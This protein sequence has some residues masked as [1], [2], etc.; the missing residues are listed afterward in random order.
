MKLTAASSQCNAH[1]PPASIYSLYLSVLIYPPHSTLDGH[2]AQARTAP[3]RCERLEAI[4]NA[5]W[6]TPLSRPLLELLARGVVANLPHFGE[7]IKATERLKLLHR[8]GHVQAVRIRL[9]VL[10]LLDTRYAGVSS[11]DSSCSSTNSLCK[12]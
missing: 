7:V 3:L 8:H 4:N 5:T 1:H 12:T 10:E 11:V 2:T 9:D 6:E